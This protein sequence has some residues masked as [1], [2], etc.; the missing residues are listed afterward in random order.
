M[1]RI[2]LATVGVPKQYSAVG[3]WEHVARLD[4]VGEHTLVD[5]PEGADIVLFTECNQLGGDWRLG[6][7]RS[8]ETARR[9]RERT[10]VY[11]QRDRPWCAFPGVYVSMPASAFDHRRQAATS[12]VPAPEPHRRLGLEAPPDV[13]PDLLASFVGSATHAVRQPIFELRS[14]RL[15]VERVEDFMFHDSTSVDFEERR[16]RFAEVLFRSKFVL[17]PRGHGT[18]SIRLFESL[19]AGR[20]PVVIS[21]Q[22]MAPPGPEWDRFAVRWSEQDPLEPL[23]DYLEEL[24]PRASAMGALARQAFLDWFAPDVLFHRV[25]TQLDELRRGGAARGFPTRGRRGR[26]YAR[27]AVAETLGRTRYEVKTRWAAR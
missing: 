5:D 3:D 4:R 13:A 24:E 21:D 8:S 10:F 22:W 14:P 12:Y 15:H 1:S 23:L 6:V 20:V 7:I 19:A 25:A 18:A 11:D 26:A 9:H 16:R 2:H 27:L 17:C